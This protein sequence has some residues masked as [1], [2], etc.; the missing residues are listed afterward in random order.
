M[1]KPLA[2]LRKCL[3]P[4]VTVILASTVF[5]ACGGGSV[6]SAAAVCH[7]WDTSAVALHNK[8]AKDAQSGNGLESFLD[9]ITAPNDLATLM[10]QMSAVAPTNIEPDFQALADAFHKASSVSGGDITDPLG[11]IASGLING[12]AVSGS[13]QRVNSYL[14]AN[15]AGSPGIGGGGSSG[16]SSVAS[17][18]QGC[19]S[20]GATDEEDGESPMAALLTGATTSDSATLRSSLSTLMTD[21]NRL[22]SSKSRSLSSDAQK[23]SK[24]IQEESPTPGSALE[25]LGRLRFAGDNPDAE[26]AAIDSS[27]TSSCN[28][29]SAFGSDALAAFKAVTPAPNPSGGVIPGSNVYGA[30]EDGSFSEVV[31]PLTL[32]YTCGTSID[33][34]NGTTGAV[35]G[36]GN[37]LPNTEN[38][39]FQLAGQRAVWVTT[40]VSPAQGLTIPTWGVTL[41]IR[42]LSGNNIGDVVVVSP[43]DEQNGQSGQ[44]QLLYAD[45]NVIIVSVESPDDQSNQLYF[46][47]PDGKLSASTPNNVEGADFDTGE[48]VTSEMVELS[49]SGPAAVYSTSGALVDDS[50]DISTDQGCG[51]NAVVSILNAN[52]G[53]SNQ[54]YD[55]LTDS[56]SGPVVTHLGAS[57]LPEDN[58]PSLGERLPTLTGIVPEGIVS[59]RF[60][61][62]V[63]L[64]RW[65]GSIGWTISSQ[66][67]SDVTV[68]GGW[69]VIQNQSNQDVVV[70]PSTG[71]QASGLS[72]ELQNVLQSEEGGEDPGNIVEIA[73]PAANE[74]VVRT[75]DNVIHRFTYTQFCR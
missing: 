54:G 32:V 55:R 43:Q 8:Y 31:E 23:L 41:H 20:G 29:V 70:D 9:V 62:D 38:P 30:C 69:V 17:S 51:S 35:A 72:D 3:I 68:V 58:D 5:T 39:S 10:D 21:L 53:D 75:S 40:D 57:A 56:P 26:L 61:G 63:V 74:V 2:V 49:A 24:Q 16:S 11:A 14:E 60:N 33:L 1:R 36:S 18:I 25:A 4:A 47:T 13:E 22:S 34:V 12:L 71:E 42:D 66:V 15:C 6:R 50:G 65:D 52:E 28:R 45:S 19:L 73:D 59:K 7:V 46:Y 44:S 37:F 64:Y 67:A 48:P 27:Y